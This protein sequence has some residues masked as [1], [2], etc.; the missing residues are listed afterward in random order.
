MPE[1]VTDQHV[2]EVIG[3]TLAKQPGELRVVPVLRIG[4]LQQVNPHVVFGD[5]HVF[6]LWKLED[7]PAIVVGMDLLGSLASMLIDYQRCE[8]QVRARNQD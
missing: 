1:R 4:S 2:T 6:K 5:F 8:L 3:E 7:E